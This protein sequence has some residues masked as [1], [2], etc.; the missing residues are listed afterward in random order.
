[1][2]EKISYEKHT[3]YYSLTLERD[4]FN[5]VVVKHYGR[6]GTQHGQIRNVAFESYEEAEQ[7][8]GR[9]AFVIRVKIGHISNFCD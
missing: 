5:W 6:I 3:R 2:N 8:F 9:G 4:L 7:Y 1:M